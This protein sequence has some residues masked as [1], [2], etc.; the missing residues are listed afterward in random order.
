[1]RKFKKLLLTVLLALAVVASSV[2]IQSIVGANEVVQAA[3]I[4]LSKSTL[5]LYVGKSATLKVS[6]TKSKVKWSSSNKRVA[7]VTS[8]GKVTAKM[9]GKAT[10]S[11]KVG[12]KTLKCKVTVK[13]Q[14]SASEATKK[15]SVTL[16]D[17]GKGIV[18]ILKN[19]NKVAVNLSAKLVYY[20]NGKMIDTASDS[21]YAFESGT[22][23]ALFFYG[24]ID[25]DY[26]IAEYDDYKITLS[27]EKGTNLV[28]GRKGINIESNFGADNV[29]AE[30]TN[31]SGKDLYSIQVA[32]VF[33]DANGN[34]IGH[35]YH[36]AKCLTNGSV[37]YLSF[38]FPYDSNY[39]TIQPSSYKVY[40]NNAYTYTWMQ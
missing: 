38:D 18:A 37:D 10:I 26:N 6:G 30:V 32:V 11:A 35:E 34:A 24:P 23:C 17:T 3:N 12:K 36:Y 13:E 39:D 20:K 28:C 4:K 27:V 25:S 19:N 15:I 16:Q 8:K 29:S 9:V 21:N 14:F 33:Y 7:T 22:E 2:P 31:N 40:V 5:N 1:M